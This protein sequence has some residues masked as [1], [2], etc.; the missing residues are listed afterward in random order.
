MKPKLMPMAI[1]AVVAAL[2]SLSPAAVVNF[3]GWAYG[4]GNTV[5]VGVPNHIGPAGGFKGSLDFN[6][7][8]ETAGWVDRPG[9]TFLSY[10]VEINEHFGFSNGDM[11]DYTVVS[12][13]SYVRSFYPSSGSLGDA[14]ADRIGQLMSYV[15]AD[16]TRVDSAVESTSLQLAIWNLVYDSDN[17]VLEGDFKENTGN[18]ADAYANTLLTV[19]LS[20]QNQYDVFVLTKSGS[21]DF[22]LLRDRGRATFSEVP[23]PASLALAVTALGL[24]GA[25]SR[26][27]A[28]RSLR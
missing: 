1:A 17:T 24:L 22:L 8:E 12:A 10:C 23:E 26:R 11:S 28:A 19:S 20:T 5:N 13:S 6:A 25:R 14:K 7:A 15:A 4:S 16:A 3:N 2:P 27:G 9:S 21:Q 18:G